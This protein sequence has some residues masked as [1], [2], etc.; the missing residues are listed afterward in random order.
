MGGVNP[1]AGPAPATQRI[2][3]QNPSMMGLGQGAGPAPGG[4]PAASQTDLSLSCGG[5]DAQQ[6]I[7]S[8][9]PMHPAHA[10]QQ[11]LPVSAMQTYRQ[12]MLA[13]QQAHLKQQQMARMTGNI[14]MAGSMSSMAGSL[15]GTMGSNIQSGMPPQAQ[16]WQSQQHP[17][18]GNGAMQAG[19]PNAS[20]H[21]QPRMTKLPG[22]AQFGQAGMGTGVPGRVMVG[23]NPAQMMPAMA[24]QR[25]NGASMAQQQQQP[26]QGQQV[27]PDLG[28]F[29][30]AAQVSS[31]TTGMQCNQAY[32]VNRTANQQMPFAYNAQS[33]TSL[34]GF[35]GD[36]DLD[37]LL[38]HQTEEW[39]DDLNE[40]LASHQ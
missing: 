14:P 2:F 36:S 29:G 28:P 22:N 24:Q 33:A 16:T 15:P 6:V 23:M 27:L 26:Q 38:K 12:N 20:F 37:S 30:Q 40:L 31:R 19:F 1:L 21:M 8:G 18:L 11:R 4:P 17:G 13:Q 32:Q 3:Q 39:M 25:S 7:Y 35:P 34:P 10:N 9:M 5:M